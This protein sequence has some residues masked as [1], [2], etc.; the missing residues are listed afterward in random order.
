MG[1]YAGLFVGVIIADNVAQIAA[2]AIMDYFGLEN[3]QILAV[4]GLVASLGSGALIGSWLGPIGAAG[5]AAMGAGYWSVSQAVNALFRIGQGPAWNWVYIETGYVGQKT[6]KRDERIYF[7]SYNKS[8]M[9]YWIAYD[10]KYLASFEDDCFSAG[11]AV[12][13][14]FQVEVETDTSNAAHFNEVWHRDLIRVAK[15]DA[16][17]ICTMHCHGEYWQSSAG[18]CVKKFAKLI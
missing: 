15:S 10:R 6:E 8:D 13:D 1:A 9:L 2:G 7:Y 12:D 14:F 3:R 4:T 16:N 5:G 17:E 11:Q 18:L